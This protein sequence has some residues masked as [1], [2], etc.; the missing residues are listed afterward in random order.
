MILFHPT[1]STTEVTN[2]QQQITNAFQRQQQPNHHIYHY[3]K[4]SMSTESKPLP[5]APTTTI[6]ARVDNAPHNNNN[7][8]DDDDNDNTD[9]SNFDQRDRARW[10]FRCF[11]SNLG[12][13]GVQFVSPATFRQ[14]FFSSLDKA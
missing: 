10:N 11:Q 9:N 5:L 6:R 1:L 4:T 13:D 12:G 8:K 14:H 3:N 7:S 2:L